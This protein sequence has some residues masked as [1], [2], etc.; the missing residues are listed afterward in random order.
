VARV[1]GGHISHFFFSS[2]LQP[3]I[4][5]RSLSVEY[6]EN[7]RNLIRNK[8]LNRDFANSLDN[9]DKGSISDQAFQCSASSV[10][11]IPSVSGSSKLLAV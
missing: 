8:D 1:Y 11:S 5:G 9:T 4:D 10:E 6:K 7:N 3:N 2:V